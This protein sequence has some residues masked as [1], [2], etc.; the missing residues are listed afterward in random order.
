VNLASEA[1]MELWHK[2]LGHMSEKGLKMLMNKELLPNIKHG[3]LKTCTYCLAGKQN[4]VAFKRNSCSRK[5]YVLDLVH[6]DV[7]YMKDRSIGGALY[8]VTFIDDHSRK[9]CTYALKSKDQV[10]NVF[11]QYHSRVER[12]TRRKLICVRADNG[13]EYRG[14]F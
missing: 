4:K 8:F 12:E 9:F 5:A 3:P 6:A 10:L 14:P 7:C 1:S 13:G 11:K 2:R